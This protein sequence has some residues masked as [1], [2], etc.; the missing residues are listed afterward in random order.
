MA[1]SRSGLRPPRLCVA[2]S[3]LLL[4]S[5]S[6]A[7]S[8]TSELTQ[9]EHQELDSNA[10]SSTDL[11]LPSSGFEWGIGVGFAVPFG[12][13]DSGARVF[14]AAPGGGDAS[15]QIRDG[16]MGG[17]VTY[18]V[19]LILELGY[20]LSPRW[21]IGLRPEIATGGYG[22]QCPTAADCKWTDLRLGALAKLH[23]APN[24]KMDPWLGVNL[25][26]EWLRPSASV[27]LPGEVTGSATAQS[28]NI[29]QTIGGPLL[30][31]LGGLAFDFG[32]HIQAGPFVSAAVG[33]YVRSWFECSST[34][35]GCAQPSWIDDGAFHGWVSIGIAGTHGP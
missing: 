14:E 19:P 13:A 25:G 3:V 31:V 6:L 33:R 27:T 30:E 18:R 23:F 10:S 8:N 35:I 2:V 16:S 5:A 7:E 11:T 29:K 9:S 28:V 15:M 21:W 12:H 34:A 24:T 26:W 1:S 4:S 32:E 22:G 17:L 20:R